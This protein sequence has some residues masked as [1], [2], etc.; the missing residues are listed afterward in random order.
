VLWGRAGGLTRWRRPGAEAAKRAGSLAWSGSKALRAGEKA[1]GLGSL[2]YGGGRFVIGKFALVHALRTCEKEMCVRGYS[3]TASVTHRR[4]WFDKVEY[5]CPEG[6][7][8]VD[9]PHATR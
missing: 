4:F 6:G 1:F 2:V 8:L 7:D 5:C 3:A 9:D